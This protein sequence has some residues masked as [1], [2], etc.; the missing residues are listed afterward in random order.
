MQGHDLKKFK[1]DVCHQLQDDNVLTFNIL[2]SFIHNAIE[3]ESTFNHLMF[4]HS[5]FNNKKTLSHH[6]IRCI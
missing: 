1:D 6:L 3:V 2:I 4:Y 5:K